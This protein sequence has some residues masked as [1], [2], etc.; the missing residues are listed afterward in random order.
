MLC[1]WRIKDAIVWFYF[2]NWQHVKLSG[3]E[4]I[5]RLSWLFNVYL[6]RPLNNS[7]SDT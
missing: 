1:I 2:L 6:L 7:E 4:K 3:R 5:L